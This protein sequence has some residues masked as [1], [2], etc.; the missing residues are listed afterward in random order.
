MKNI[1][2]VICVTVLAG[3][4]FAC[5]NFAAATMQPM[6]LRCEYHVDPLGIDVQKP[7]LSWRLESDDRGQKQSAYRIL[8]ASTPEKLKENNGDLWDRGKVLSDISNQIIYQGEALASHQRCYWKVMVWDQTDHASTWS[9]PAMWSMGLLEPDDWEAEWIGYDHIPKVEPE[10][11]ET[12]TAEIVIKEA[13][14]G[15]PDDPTKQINLLDKLQAQVDAGNYEFQMTNVFAGKDPAGGVRKKLKLEY[16]LNGLPQKLTINENASIDLTV[17]RPFKAADDKRYLPSPHLRKEFEVDGEV[18]RAVIYFTAQGFAEMHLNGQRIGDEFFTPPGWT[19]YRER[20]YYGTYDVTN[21]LRQGDNAIAGILGDGWFRG[22]ISTKGQNQYGDK[23]RLLSQLQIDYVDGRSEIISSDNTWKAAF[24]PIQE[25]DMQAGETYDARLEMPGWN[26]S[27]FDDSE[28]A[29]VD[30]GSALNTEPLIQAYPGPPVRRTEEL[31]VVEITE[32]MD[33]LYVF[34]LGQNFSGWIRLKVNGEAGDK[35]VMRFGEML[36]EDGTVYTENLRSA[37]ATDTYILKGGGTE[38][39]EPHF[40]FHGFRYVEVMGLPAQPNEDTMTGIAVN[41][42][43]AM[44]SS[45]ECSDPMLNQL[46]KNIVWGQRSN[47]LD[48]P[49]DCPQR[50]ERLGWTG[51]AQVFI[52][53]GTYHMDSAAFYTKWMVDVEDTQTKSGIFGLQA[54]KFHGVGCPGWSDA[55]VICPWTIYQVYGDRRIL[56]KHYEAMAA[57][58]AYCKSQGMGGMGGGFGDWLAVGSKT[59]KDVISTA[60][61]AY[62]TSLMAEIAEA[63]GKVEDAKKYQELFGRIRAYFQKEFV[64]ADGRVKG[65]TQTAYCMALYYDLLNKQQREQAAAHLVERIEAKDYHL[66]VGFLGVRLLLPTL[67]QIGR[68]DLAYQLLQNTTYPSWGYSVEQGATTVWERW[69]SYTLEGGINEKSMNS[70]NHYAYGACSEWMFYTML[71]I[72]T[73]GAGFRD[74]EMKPEVGHGITWAKGH[75]DSI[76]GRI[77][78]SWAIEDKL[79]KWKVEIPVNTTATLHV[80]ATS[81][82]KVTENGMAIEEVPALTFL[83]EKDGRVVLRAES[84][85]YQFT[86]SE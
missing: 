64:D 32:P 53:S 81:I 83:Q 73:D 7:R 12:K 37:R 67:T 25:S 51:D 27:G 55:G 30:T 76:N 24:G 14:Y 56:E 18:E 9:E 54:P 28:W 43:A 26:Q 47:Y 6:E 66:S 2:S 60:Y 46:H 11:I 33:E 3:L 62:S 23:I 86:V 69:D 31:P 19:D 52:R 65:N 5:S 68:S 71:G 78:S 45:F 41:S 20:I 17:G 85:L 80:P 15:V 84:G 22:N 74:I 61:F 82:G 36:N 63:L 42:D 48:I 59:P 16:T 29:Q 50:D 44:T 21:L 1:R 40:T 34:D 77:A 4:T 57:F 13:L 39:W 79:F 70:F 10:P 8:V 49:T 35:V 38:V 58:I 72:D 75:Y